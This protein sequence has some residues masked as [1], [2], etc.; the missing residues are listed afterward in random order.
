M[1]PSACAPRRLR[2]C[3]RMILSWRARSIGSSMDRTALSIVSEV[4]TVESWREQPQL[5]T[6]G[7]IMAKRLST[8]TLIEIKKIRASNDAYY[9]ALS[10]RDMRACQLPRTEIANFFLNH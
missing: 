10:A 7:A 2:D 1:R 4:G 9:K 5:F 6:R 8:K 3:T